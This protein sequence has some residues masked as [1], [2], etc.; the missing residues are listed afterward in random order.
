MQRYFVE[1]SSTQDEFVIAGENAR[2]I[3]KVM[4]MAVGDEIILVHDNTAFI[5]E[6]TEIDQD[7]TAKK[8]VEQ[9]RHLKCP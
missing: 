8:L 3:S 7:V 9:L 6:I 4:R 5:C 1:Q 2:H